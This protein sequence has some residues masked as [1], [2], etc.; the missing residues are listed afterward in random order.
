MLFYC[1]LCNVFVLDCSEWFRLVYG[2]LYRLYCIVYG[3]LFRLYCIRLG[4]ITA[5][6]RPH[7]PHGTV[8]DCTQYLLLLPSVPH[9]PS[10]PM[11]FRLILQSIRIT[12]EILLDPWL[13]EIIWVL[14]IRMYSSP[15]SGV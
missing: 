13:L 2:L 14:S 1:T 3:L 8:G 6:I 12:S 11:A 15:L 5:A 7:C 10:S 9:V 4:T